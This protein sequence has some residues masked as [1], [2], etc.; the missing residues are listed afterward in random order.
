MFFGSRNSFDPDKD[1]PS[2]DGK[3][4]LVTGGSNGLGKQAVL[5]FAK[6]RPQ[7]IWLAARSPDKAQTA[8]DEIRAQVPDAPIRTL[9][10]DLSSFASVRRAA[11][12]FAAASDRLD[13]LMLN[14]GVMAC[15]AGL[16]EDGYEVQ[17]GTNHMGHALLTKL[18]LPVLERTAAARTA[19]AANVRVVVLSSGGHKLGPKEG[20]CF[21]TLKTPCADIGTMTR[22]GQSKF[23][24][25]LFARRLAQLYPWLTAAAVHPGVVRTNLIEGASG[26]PAAARLLVAG[27]LVSWFLTSVSEG[28]RNQ[29]WAAVADGVESGEY[30]EPVGVAGRA[31][32]LGR[33]DGLARA[34]WEWTE[35]ELDAAGAGAGAGAGEGTSARL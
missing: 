23:A 2:L 18:L 3:V 10:M 28:T 20:I 32:A 29:L 16:T 24:N 27:P 34:L 15:E 5:E 6:H 31:R 14:A 33:N 30:Y 22:Y 19:G 11:R 7:Q 8:V 4:I 21:D 9:Q 25:I 17:F 26:L 12:E 13:I 1:I 35:A